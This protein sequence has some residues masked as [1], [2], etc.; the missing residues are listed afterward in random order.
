MAISQIVTNS[1]ATGAVS[2][3]DLAAGAARANFGAGAVLQVSQA[4][5]TGT[6]LIPTGG[7]NANWTDITSL[8]V[9]ITPSSSSSKMLLFANVNTCLADADRLTFL[10]FTGGNSASYRGASAGNRTPVSA[11][12]YAGSPAV[13]AQNMMMS[14][15]DSPATTSAITYKVQAAP[16][17]NAGG[18]LAINY[19][20]VND[21]DQPYIPRGASSLIVM[22]IAG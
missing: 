14:Y 3:A 4:I 22:E 21:S 19:Y 5:F 10:R 17:F 16:N 12:N 13:I 15:V 2:A 8:S 1:I 20:V 9:T 18:G 6:Q 11:F 7:V